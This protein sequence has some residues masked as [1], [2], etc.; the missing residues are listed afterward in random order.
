MK[1]RRYYGYLNTRCHSIPNTAYCAGVSR[2]TLHGK[3]IDPN[4]RRKTSWRREK[5]ERFWQE[6][7]RFRYCWAGRVR[8]RAEALRRHKRA[9]LKELPLRKQ[10]SGS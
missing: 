10:S 2:M 9:F 3:V 4:E 1:R 7:Q 6:Q 5:E 8:W